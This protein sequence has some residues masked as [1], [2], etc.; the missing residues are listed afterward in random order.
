MS[1]TGILISKGAAMDDNEF[2]RELDRRLA[3]V[4]DPAY[5]DPARVDLPVRDLVVLLVGSVA[6]I[7][8]AL[9]W[10]YPW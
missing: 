8:A 2:R 4:E 1:S 9:G 5:D 6:V 7:V 10:G 3:V